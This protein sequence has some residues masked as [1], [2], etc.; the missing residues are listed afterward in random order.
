MCKVMYMTYT[1]AVTSQGQVSIPA[2]VRKMW[3][4]MK[5]GQITFT[6]QGK[7][8][9][10]EPALDILDLAGSLHKYAKVNKGLT[11]RQILAREKKAVEDAIVEQYLRK[12]KRS[13]NKLLAIKTW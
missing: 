8:A 10:V 13:G 9:I 12:E 1:L 5:R 4:L 6:L 7:K 3:G 2:K 11:S